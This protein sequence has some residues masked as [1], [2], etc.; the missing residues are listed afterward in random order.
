MDKAEIAVTEVLRSATGFFTS[1][2]GAFCAGRLSQGSCPATECTCK[3][4][5][6]AQSL[7]LFGLY[8]ATG[9]F[10][11]FG[12]GIVIGGASVYY[13]TGRSSRRRGVYTAI[14]G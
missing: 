12:A 10:I 11:L 5:S 8:L 13:L 2:H 14:Q 9:G 1:G 3:C 6:G 7:I 4:D